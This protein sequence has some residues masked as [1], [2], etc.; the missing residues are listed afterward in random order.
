MILFGVAMVLAIQL[1]SVVLTQVIALGLVD[2]RDWFVTYSET[3][4]LVEVGLS[5]VTAIGA[6]RCALASEGRARRGFA[7]ATI[8]ILAAQVMFFLPWLLSKLFDLPWTVDMWLLRAPF[9]ASTAAVFAYSVA[10]SGLASHR[11]LVRALQIALALDLVIAVISLVFGGDPFDQPP[12]AIR[13][14]STVA[15]A[16]RQIAWL[17]LVLDVLAA[18]AESGDAPMATVRATPRRVAGAAAVAL[19][20]IGTALAA[21]AWWATR[22]VS[23][24]STTDRTLVVGIVVFVIGAFV[25]ARMR[26]SV[27]IAV[28]CLVAGTL[29]AAAMAVTRASETPLEHMAL[30]PQHLPGLAISLPDGKVE[31]DI[32]TQELGKLT[33]LTY[34]SDIGLVTLSWRRGVRSPIEEIDKVHVSQ[35]DNT[36]F[37]EE[38]H[39]L[40]IRGIVFTGP[41]ASRLYASWQCPGDPRWFELEMSRYQPSVEA[42]RGVGRRIFDTIACGD[43][44]AAPLFAL[45]FTPP[46]GYVADAAGQPLRWSSGDATLVF[47]WSPD[48][49][50]V[51]TLASDPGAILEVVGWK[52]HAGDVTW[53]PDQ[54]MPTRGKIVESD[55]RKLAEVVSGDYRVLATAWRCWGLE[56]DVLGLW[57]GPSSLPREA[58]VAALRAARCPS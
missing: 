48:D 47:Y 50:Y 40:T 16:A 54:A 51:D 9:F 32:Y 53:L 58:A 39:G 2:I 35:I 21:C 43:A 25:L 55:T 28:P 42:L 52:E 49:D 17:Y 56:I 7:T 1:V 37:V 4:H 13:I 30:V 10:A 29:I 38:V 15:D 8:L 18:F 19:C 27:P 20:V 26:R 33:I 36:P 3:T 24:A 44:T 57:I 14:A 6:A 11:A 22:L 5:V 45:A 41:A 31:R 46:A 12:Q 34:H 23:S